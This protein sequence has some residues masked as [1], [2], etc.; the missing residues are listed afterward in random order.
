VHSYIVA[1]AAVGTLRP[2]TLRAHLAS[3]TVRLGLRGRHRAGPVL[4]RRPELLGLG[5]RRRCVQLSCHL[6][7]GRMHIRS[8]G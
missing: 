4:A 6:S 3:S 8:P 5:L 1:A 2:L 7:M